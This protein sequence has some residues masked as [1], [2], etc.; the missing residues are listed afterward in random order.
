MG[1]YIVKVKVHQYMLMKKCKVHHLLTQIVS[2]IKS[3]R[4]N[5]EPDSAP[6]QDWYN[7]VEQN[8]D[9]GKSSFNNHCPS[10]TEPMHYKI[11]I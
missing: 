11:N 4:E 1:F 2:S 7:Q 10:F 9:N 3:Q 6:A 8:D 5:K